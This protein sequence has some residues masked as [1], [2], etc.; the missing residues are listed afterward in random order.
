VNVEISM[1]SITLE[2]VRAAS[3]RLQGHVRVTP[4]LPSPWLSAVSGAS[5]HLK[6]ESLQVTSSFKSRGALNALTRL[7]DE[8]GP[9]VRVVTASAGN[10]GRAVAWAAERLGLRATV[11]TPRNAPAAKLD[12]IRAH[13]A[14]LRA[15]AAD[16]EE[17]EQNAKAFAH[18]SGAAFVSPYSHP[19]VIAGAGTI[20]LELLQDLPH[21]DAAIVPLGGGGL[22]S[23]IAV[24]IKALRPT[25]AVVGVE[26]EASSAFHAARAAGRIVRIA[27]GDTI[28]D[29]LGGNVDPDTLTW[30]L[31]RDVVDDVIVVSEV[32]L[33]RALRGLVAAEHLVAE[34]A[35]VAAIAAVA[36]RRVDLSGGTGAAILSG[37]NIDIGRLAGILTAG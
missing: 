32:E 27:V 36:A 8:H 14:D 10:H 29:G 18:A 28:A 11:F 7:R 22:V 25:T 34:G 31:I 20:G 15:D 16:Y 30:P 4:I 24:A 26:V 5:I 21:L 6:L 37:A 3:R 13:G 35:G 2:D 1:A 23:G 17:S 19:D 9:D 33:R 12:P